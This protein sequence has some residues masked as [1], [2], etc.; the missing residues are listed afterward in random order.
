MQISRSAWVAETGRR[1]EQQ[2]W[3][4]GDALVLHLDRPVRSFQC[5]RHSHIFAL[6]HLDHLADL[7]LS[8]DALQAHLVLDLPELVA[9]RSLVCVLHP[10]FSSRVRLERP[11]L[12][13]PDDLL[14]LRGAPGVAAGAGEGGELSFV[15]VGGAEGEDVLDVGGEGAQGRRWRGG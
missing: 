9:R 1:S 6:L 12:E 13:L 15:R 10:D 4:N 11:V 8:R 5:A 3:G 2:R 7:C 14:E